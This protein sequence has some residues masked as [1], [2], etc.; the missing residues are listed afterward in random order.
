MICLKQPKQTFT[1]Q[2]LLKTQDGGWKQLMQEKAIERQKGIGSL[3]N[4]NNKLSETRNANIDIITNV[5]ANARIEI[6]KN[7]QIKK[8]ELKTYNKKNNSIEGNGKHV[9]LDTNIKL[10]GKK[11]NDNY[12]SVSARSVQSTTMLEKKNIVDTT[13]V[14]SKAINSVTDII[15]VVSK[16]PIK[17]SN[18]IRNKSATKKL[19]K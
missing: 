17:S 13:K 7:V 1:R 5:K 15:N 18:N 12:K 16:A 14:R 2:E 9:I 6:V 3:N 8:N 11:E 10:S 19:N 4:R